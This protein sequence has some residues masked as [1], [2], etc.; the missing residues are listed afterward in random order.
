MSNRSRD[1]DS[2]KCTWVRLGVSALVLVASGGTMT[3]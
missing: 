3:L 1:D 2:C